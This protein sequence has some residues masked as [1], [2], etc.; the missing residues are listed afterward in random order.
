[1]FNPKTNP[2][3][4]YTSITIGTVVDTNDPQQTGRLR[5]V[6][7]SYGDRS[8]GL[9]SD[10]PWA[11]YISPLAGTLNNDNTKR[12]T[13]QQASH[14]PISY[15]MW[16]IPKVGAAVAV[17]CID[18][19]PMSRIWLGCLQPEML[20]HT[21]PHGRYII[22]N[23]SEPDGPLNSQEQQIQPTYNNLTTAFGSRNHNYEWRTR[24]ADYSAAS[25]NAQQFQVISQ[26]SDDRGVSF[27][28]QDG[29]TTV[30]QQGYSQSQIEPDVTFAETTGKNYDSHTYSWTTPGFHSISMDDRK[31]NCRMKFRTTAGHQIILDDTNERVYINTAEGRNWIELDQDGNIDIYS[32]QKV[33]VRSE[34]D[35]NLS[36]D[37]TVRLFGGQGIH[38][39]SGGEIRMQ[40]QADL[41]LKSAAAIRAHSDTDTHFESGGVFSVKTAGDMLL[42]TATNMNLMASGEGRMTSSGLLS[43]TGSDIYQTGGQIHFNGPT[44]TQAQMASP[45]GEQPAFWTNRLPA[46]EPYG[47]CATSGDFT[48]DPKYQYD[49]PAMGTDDKARGPYWRR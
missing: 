45:A 46:H 22:E 3:Q 30:F 7:P 11:S 43:L 2:N 8:D 21:L 28:A 35:I 13:E 1:M 18:G 17:T 34:S 29:K 42:D 31:E 49:D 12:G 40:S 25:I 24:G 6:V 26:T 23:G 5:V 16:N 48:H 27:T 10:L 15:G 36:S 37:K 44:A 41:H 32:T 4:V 19:D 20:A 47:R 9:V 33:S 38:M 14:G 39:Y